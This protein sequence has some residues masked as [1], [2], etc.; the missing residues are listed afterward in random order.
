MI[1][2][3]NYIFLENITLFCVM[4]FFRQSSIHVSKSDSFKSFH[5]QLL[6]SRLRVQILWATRVRLRKFSRGTF[7]LFHHVLTIFK[8]IRV[9][10]DHNNFR[11]LTLYVFM[12]TGKSEKISL[13]FLKKLF[14]LCLYIAYNKYFFNISINIKI[15]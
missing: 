10:K 11:S 2:K 3:I 7:V 14:N 8:I 4:F 12:P 5:F 15:K 1:L 6:L 13:K 9:S